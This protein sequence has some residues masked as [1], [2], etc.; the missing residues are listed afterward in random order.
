MRANNWG[1]D[2]Y[3]LVNDVRCPANF[4]RHES[5]GPA[6]LASLSRKMPGIAT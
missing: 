4:R 3:E 6:C 2:A 1:V 5:R